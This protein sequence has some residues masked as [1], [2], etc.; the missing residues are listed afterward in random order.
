MDCAEVV[1]GQSPTHNR[2]TIL[3]ILAHTQTTLTST[4]RW[5]ACHSHW[6]EAVAVAYAELV[7][8]PLFSM[9]RPRWCW[10]AA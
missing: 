8:V 7:G 3:L 6:S 4:R 9:K 2:A 1:P 10:Y 5:E